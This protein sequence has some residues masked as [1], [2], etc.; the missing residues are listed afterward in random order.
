MKQFELTRRATLAA[1]GAVAV[2]GCAHS[3]ASAAAVTLDEV[4]RR[5]TLARGGVAALDRVQ[6][7]TVDVEI[8]EGGQTLKGLYAANT[9]GLVRVD[10]YAGG[11]LVASEGIDEEGVWI[12]GRDGP[13]PSVATG[14]ANA[15]LHGAENHLFGWHRFR[16]RG[17]ELKLMP[18]ATLDGT[19]HQVVQVVYSTGHVSYYYVDPVSW[20]AVRRRDERAYHPDIDQKKQRVESR[21]LDWTVVEGVVAAH[22]NEDYDIDIGK[23]LAVNRVLSRQINPPLA[24]DHFD[25][26][27]RAPQSL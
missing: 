22:R 3:P 4:I 21:S 8:V 19:T 20:Q 14:A 26:N 6:A 17:H 24:S 2:T 9:A 1:L 5:N 12:L 11:K 16:E 7:I 10:V 18:P 25:R 13:R 23:L 27:R 15:L